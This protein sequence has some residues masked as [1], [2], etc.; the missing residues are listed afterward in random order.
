M[1]IYFRFLF[2]FNFLTDHHKTFTESD[3]HQEVAFNQYFYLYREFMFLCSF[4]S[5]CMS[6]FGV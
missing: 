1:F 5:I 4:L 3:F 2:C 6:V